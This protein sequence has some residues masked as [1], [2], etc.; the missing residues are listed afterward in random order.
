VVSGCAIFRDGGAPK[1]SFDVEKDLEQLA[2]KYKEATSI[3]EFYKNPSEAARNEFVTGRLVMMNIR[4]I[5]FIRTM[6]R[7]KQLLDAATD[8]LLVSLN[9]TGAGI[10]GE[11]AK[12]I[13]SSLAAGIGASKIAVDKN[14]YYEKTVPALVASMNAERAAVLEG[15]TANL[16]K[17]LTLYPFTDAVTDVQRYYEAGTLLGAINSIQRDAASKQ[18]K[19]TENIAILKDL[20]QEDIDR[21]GSM[22]KAIGN[23][24][25]ADLQNA[26]AT[27]AE[28]NPQVAAPTKI[29]DAKLALQREVRQR[30]SPDEI[31]KAYDIF[32]KHNLVQ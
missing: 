6:T 10:S 28:L 13:F 27:L 24:K 16:K 15:I 4:Y 25:D 7:E 1:Q 20:T 18:A 32:K 30:R 5:E 17:P 19:A 2:A 14:F 3:A 9:L 26:Q 22:T 12:T 21:K 11:T 29:D 23:L 31:Q 8:I